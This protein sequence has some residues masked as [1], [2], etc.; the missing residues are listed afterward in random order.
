MRWKWQSR[1]R[2]DQPARG[3]YDRFKAA[4]RM[5]PG[6]RPWPSVTSANASRQAAIDCLQSFGCSNWPAAGDLFC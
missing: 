2:S 4:G 3:R 6:R 1:P 5:P